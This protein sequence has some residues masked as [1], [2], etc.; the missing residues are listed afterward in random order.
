[1]VLVNFTEKHFENYLYF[2]EYYIVFVTSFQL[3]LNKKL[4]T[5]LKKHV[6]KNFDSKID[7]FIGQ[8]CQPEQATNLSKPKLAT[9]T[10]SVRYEGKGGFTW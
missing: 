6:Y 4:G 1:M 9:Y 2:V 3:Y 5:V 8:F 10:E 7:W